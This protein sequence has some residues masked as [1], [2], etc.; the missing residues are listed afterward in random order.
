MA[1]KGRMSPREPRARKTIVLEVDAMHQ[2]QG[3][4]SHSPNGGPAQAVALVPVYVT[5][6]K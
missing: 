6:A 5:G 1:S 4:A 3:V 2:V